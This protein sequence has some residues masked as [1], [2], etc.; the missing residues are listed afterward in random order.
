[1]IYSN[2]TN[3]SKQIINYINVLLSHKYFVLKSLY[4]SCYQ[5]D[6]TT[7]EQKS[8]LDSFENAK[9]G[10]ISCVYCLSEGYDFP[11]LDGVVFSEN[12]SSDIRIVQAALRASRKNISEKDK[13]TKII[14]PTYIDNWLDDDENVDY[15]KVRNVIHQMSIEDETIKQKI[16]VLHVDIEKQK[17]KEKCEIMCNVGFEKYDDELTKKLNLKTINRIALNVTY[18]QAKKIVSNKNIKSKQEYHDLCDK[19]FR[20]P[21]EPDIIFEKQFTNWIDYL[22]IERKYYDIETCKNKIREHFVLKLKMKKQHIDFDTIVNELCKNDAMFP[23][24]DLWIEYYCV[25]NL[26]ELFVINVN[27]KSGLSYK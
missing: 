19:D 7:Q 24:N 27:K 16:K 25:K 20:L 17:C 9:Y 12:M 2:N 1:L 13:I 8:A 21:K 14:L 23:P 22:N 5:S 10:I 3:N 26:R 4:Y 18:S 6:M 15:K 11:K